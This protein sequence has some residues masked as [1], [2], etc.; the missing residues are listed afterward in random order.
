MKKA[1]NSDWHG[2]NQQYLRAALQNVRVSLEQHVARQSPGSTEAKASSSMDLEEMAR[3]LPW[4]PALERL[5]AT[6]ELSP[7]ERDVLLLCAGMELDSSFVSL[8]AAAQGDA[9]RPY[10]TFSLALAA[11]S[12]SHWSALTPAAPLRYWRLLEVPPGNILTLSPLRIDERI[13]TYLTGLQQIDERLGGLLEFVPAPGN[14]LPFQV[15]A[16]DGLAAIWRAGFANGQGGLPVLQLAGSDVE[17]KTA[18]A[19][20]ACAAVGLQLYRIRASLLPAAPSELTAFARLWEREAALGTCA[21]LVYGDDGEDIEPG[22]WPAIRTLLERT[23]GVLLVASREGQRLA[24]RPSITVE[25]HK[26]TGSEKRALWQVAL[27]E[28]AAALDGKLENILE[29]FSLSASAIRSVCAEVA[30]QLPR[31]PDAARNRAPDVARVIWDACRRQARPRLDDLALRIEPSATLHD[32]VLPGSQHQLLREI[33]VHVQQRAKVYRTWGFETQGPRGLGISALFVGLSGTGKTMAAE[34]LAREL[35]LDLYRVDLSQVVSKYIGETEKN[36]R[37][38]FDAAEEGGAILLFDEADALFGKRSEVRDSHDRYA[39]IE[40]SYLLQ[41]MESYHGLAI[42]TTNMKETLDSAFLRRIRFVVEFPF[43]DASQ[44]A[45]IWQR[46][47]PPATPTQG[48][49]PV[50]LASLNVAGGNI[51]NIALHAA[52]LAAEAGESVRMAH[53]VRGARVEYGKLDR[54]LTEAEIRGW[55]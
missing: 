43:P 12:K 28:Q 2:A 23:R 25:F 34:A 18:V 33:A 19:A 44:R 7:F 13:L 3:A 47:F 49:D 4:P 5:C 41:R 10:P 55:T 22:R 40:I 9:Q 32:V 30:G 31:A 42:L 16:V 8:C 37:R 24:G 53:L 36:L 29:Q 20:G 51:R 21:L 50:K 27:G 14:L 54:P 15:Q 48:L 39:N 1:A 52:F 46:I 17:S 11:L 45:E 38:V 6:F 35:R 26:P